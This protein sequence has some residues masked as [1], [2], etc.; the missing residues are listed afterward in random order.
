MSSLAGGM[1]LFKS[2]KKIRADQRLFT[3][4]PLCTSLRMGYTNLRHHNP[5][6]ISKTRRLPMERRRRLHN[7]LIPYKCTKGTGFWATN[8]NNNKR[9]LG[10]MMMNTC[11]Y[12]VLTYPR[13]SRPGP[14]RGAVRSG[15]SNGQHLPIAAIRLEVSSLI[16]QCS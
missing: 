7:Q 13:A 14:T 16:N 3:T 8:Q 12:E 1:C 10:T 9:T 15:K 6:T 11:W 4:R 5:Q 2:N